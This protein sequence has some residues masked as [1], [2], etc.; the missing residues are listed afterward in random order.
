MIQLFEWYLLQR[1]WHI[2]FVSDLHINWKIFVVSQ[3]FEL[4][5]NNNKKCDH[6]LYNVFKQELSLFIIVL[7][8]LGMLPKN[9]LRRFHTYTSLS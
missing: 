9:T 5:K 8:W 2:K 4:I 3:K 1:L 6:L 7:Q